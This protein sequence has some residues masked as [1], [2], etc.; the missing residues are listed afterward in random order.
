VAEVEVA[1]DR[2]Q[3][4]HDT[5]RLIRQVVPIANKY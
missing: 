2:Q 4:P 5:L 3:Y 1:E